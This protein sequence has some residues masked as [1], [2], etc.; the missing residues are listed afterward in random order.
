MPSLTLTIGWE[1]LDSLLASG[2]RIMAAANHAEVGLDHEASPLDIDWDYLRRLER[3]NI[4]WVI[5]ARLDGVLVGY[6]AFHMNRHHRHR[7]TVW[8]VNSVLYMVPEARRWTN[9]LRFLRESDRLLK[10]A[11][12]AKIQYGVQLHVKL[13]ISEG[14]LGD[15]LKAL[16]YRHTA[17]IF[18]KVV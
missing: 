14:N 13:G 16:G 7:G 5:S 12:A 9:G 2:L 15:L 4:Y 11:G 17:E 18:T 6:N 8:A 10:E 3:D 1:K